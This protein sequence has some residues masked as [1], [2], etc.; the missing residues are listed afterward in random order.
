MCVH[1]AGEVEVLTYTVHLC[2][3]Q[4]SAKFDG[5]W[6]TTS[7]SKKRLAYLFVDTLCIYKIVNSGR[8]CT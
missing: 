6:W 1:I 5:N 7:Y 8:V 2:L 4:L 3:L